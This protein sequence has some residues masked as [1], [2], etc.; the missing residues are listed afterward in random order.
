MNLIAL[1][2]EWSLAGVML[3]LLVGEIIRGQKGRA[4]PVF[5]V[6]FIGIAICLFFLYSQKSAES[7][8]EGLLLLDPLSRFFKFFFLL[9][10]A[11]VFIMT[12]VFFQSRSERSDEFY[13]ILWTSLLGMFFLASANEL[14]LIF[15]C[16]E[17][18][19]LSFYVMAAYLKRDLISIEAGLKYLIVGSLASAFFIFGIALIY[20][21]SGLTQLVALHDFFVQHPS[22]PFMILGILF[23]IAGLG[24]KVASVPFQLWVPDVYQGAPT[25]VVAFLSVASK[26]AGF[27]V[28]I[29]LLETTF[30]PF[31]ENTRLLFSVL[32]T[33]TLV[34]G[35]FAALL[36]KNIKRLFGYS[37]IGHAGYLLIGLAIG[38]SA[39]VSAMLVYLAAYGLTNLSA[40]TV[41]SWVTQKTGSDEIAAFRGLGKKAPFLAGCFFV[42]LLSL[43]GVPPLV[44]FF[45]KFL[46]LLGAVQVGLLWLAVLGALAVAVS[47]F[48]YLNII[49][50]MYIEESTGQGLEP[51]PTLSRFI[52][53]ALTA[54]IL[55]L[56]FYPTPLVSW[57]HA[58]SNFLP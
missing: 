15:V 27:V 29:R 14:L 33:L 20:V 21:A 25:P 41:I 57:V 49:R 3:I 48:Y 55:I 23:M 18:V 47:L 11:V 16:L 7:A 12:R 32:G 36:Q 4:L 54:S 51:M 28:L 52:L 43:A 17:I 5:R 46:I 37:S 26:A 40:F 38:Q 39:G 45:G 8:F 22:N 44:G 30:S 24:F 31:Q 58:A 50:T 2:P 42:A 53:M 1:L 9:A 35:N 6:S 13:L 34:Y 56:G 19:T 10:F